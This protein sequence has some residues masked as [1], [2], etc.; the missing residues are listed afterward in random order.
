MRFKNKNAR[1]NTQ[2]IYYF[3]QLYTLFSRYNILNVIKMILPYGKLTPSKFLSGHAPLP[4][5][6]KS[7]MCYWC[8][9]LYKT[10]VRYWCIIQYIVNHIVYNIP[11]KPSSS[12]VVL[13]KV[14]S[15]QTLHNVEKRYTLLLSSTIQFVKKKKTG[16]EGGIKLKVKMQSQSHCQAFQSLDVTHF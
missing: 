1:L 5:L 9:I 2:F 13:L 4:S 3:E 16:Q 12:Y 6:E 10:R 11:F 8:I 14:L 7:R 15:L